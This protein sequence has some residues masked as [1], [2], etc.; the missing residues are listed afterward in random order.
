MDN[1]KFLFVLL[2]GESDS[3][4][5]DRLDRGEINYIDDEGSEVMEL[6]K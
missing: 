5:Y 6:S 4:N 3:L 2:D 1:C